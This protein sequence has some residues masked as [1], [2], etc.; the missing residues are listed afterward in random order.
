MEQNFTQLSPEVFRQYLNSWEY[1]LLDLRTR[2]ELDQ[3]WKISENQLHI[4]IYQPMAWLKILA[5]DKDKKY[6][7]YCWHGIRSDNIRNFM[8]KNKFKHVFDL[9]WWI[10]AW[11]YS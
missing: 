4:D 5:L 6:L 2:E 3:Y 7:L 1:T 8:Q 11:N 10:D 9:Q